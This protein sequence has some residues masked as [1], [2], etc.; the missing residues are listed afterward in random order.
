MKRKIIAL[1]LTVI[2]I[3][4]VFNITMV[5]ASYESDEQLY[6]DLG[7]FPPKKT[8]GLIKPSLTREQFANIL[9]NMYGIDADSYT[10]VEDKAEDITKSKYKAAINYCI[11][12]QY[13]LTDEENRFNPTAPI[14]YD[15]AIRAFVTLIEYDVLIKD[16]QSMTEYMSIATKLGF[17]R[18]VKVADKNK[19]SYSELY[20][21]ASRV[22]K[23]NLPI[24]DKISVDSAESLYDRLKVYEQSGKIIANSRFGIGVSRTSKNTVNIDGTVYDTNI[25]IED[26]LVGVDVIYYLQAGVVV[27]VSPMHELETVTITPKDI[28]AVTDSGSLIIIKTNTEKGKITI[29]KSA[30]A[31]VNNKT[32]APTKKLFSFFKNGSATFVSDGSGEYAVVHM[33]LA[34]TFYVSG[35]SA[36]SYSLR[37]KE[38]GD[39]VSFEK[40]KNNLEVYRN[41]KAAE[42]TDICT[43]DVVS[44]MCDA[45]TLSDGDVVFDFNKATWAKVYATDVTLEGIVESVDEEGKIYIDEMDYTLANALTDR[46]SEGIAEKIVLGEYIIATVDNWGHIAY[47]EKDSQK[48]GYNYGY[49]IKSGLTKGSL[50]KNQEF[51]IMDEDG[52]IGV[53][54]ASE[55]IIVDGVSFNNKAYT[56]D[57]GGGNIVDL[58]KRQAIKYRLTG[59]GKIRAIDTQI[60]ASKENSS[61]FTVSL[62][63]DPYAKSQPQRRMKSKVVDRKIAV[64]DD[65]VLFVDSAGLGM[66]DPEDNYFAIRKTSTLD[67]AKRYYTALYDADDMGSAKCGVIWEQY[68]PDKL[69]ETAADSKTGLSYNTYSYMV[70]N[71]KTAIVDGEEY[72]KLSLADYKGK[73]KYDTVLGSY[74]EFYTVAP[75]DAFP[76]S[77]VNSWVHEKKY[78]DNPLLYPEGGG[79]PGGEAPIVFR[80]DGMSV[81][82]TLKAGDIVRVTLNDEGKIKYLERIF[83]FNES[84]D[85]VFAST[86]NSGTH[87]LFANLE[88]TSAG[89]FMYE[90]PSVSGEYNIF[91]TLSRPATVVLDLQTGEVTLEKDYSMVP[92]NS[93]GDSVK[94]LLRDYDGGT[95]MEYFVYKY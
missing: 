37:A 45:F 72:Y 39:F 87:I 26:L 49:L 60:M 27:S 56:Y 47:I 58:T 85:T 41:G 18:G 57:V 24:N 82:T 79:R 74:L 42:F 10:E 46:I 69:L 43:E 64:G 70:E 67:S 1:T 88:K 38:T 54:Q 92:S 4:S 44:V 14:N 34:Q 7:I 66:S 48:S 29:S 86:G 25:E 20:Q 73:V 3:M 65:C 28:E 11:E 62:S 80:K 22:M 15:D 55:R 63:F 6:I 8:T 90:N 91:N 5:S 75:S 50:S 33:N 13:L 19:L 36:S 30:V 2:M 89:L 59:D 12:R 31:N 81:G 32:M 94:V 84:K 51:K 83:D 71:V 35:T 93:V 23:I 17:L 16:K 40:V 53:Y 77:V 9:L 61:S 52:V 78:N 21:I 95:V 76:S 68:H